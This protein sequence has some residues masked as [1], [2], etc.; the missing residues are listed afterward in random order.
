MLAFFRSVKLG[1]DVNA[2]RHESAPLMER[3]MQPNSSRLMS[4]GTRG[5]C[6]FV[7]IVCAFLFTAQMATA[8]ATKGPEV[9]EKG[10]LTEDNFELKITYFKSTM[11]KNAP[12]AILL[13]GGKK[14]NRRN[15]TGSKGIASYLQEKG[16]FAVVAV[17]LRGHGDSVLPK[18]SELRKNDYQ[19][20]VLYDM[21]AVKE[22]LLEEHQ[23]GNL[24]MNKLGIVACDF[25]T[26][27][28]L[29]FTEIDW[30][31]EPYDDSTTPEQRTPRGQDVQALVL[32]SPELSTPGLAA[33]KS[34]AVIRGRDLP[35]MIGTSEKNAH[36]LSAA[37]KLFDALVAKKKKDDKVSLKRYP[38][39]YRGMDLVLQDV[40]TQHDIVDFLDK[41][42]KGFESPWRDRSSRLER[43]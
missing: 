15:W 17:D 26:S 43:E 39:D 20:M 34:A 8:Q 18:R 38:E 27:V 37:K 13:H 9:E 36:D 24:N 6:P 41:Y 35:V 4:F 21:Q 32:I 42:V 25:S 7:A 29:A 12:V 14:G 1:F 31:R 40:Q 30:E 3:H 5:L 23:K 11:K 22:F 2:T 16:G 10:L 19:N 28:A 33:T